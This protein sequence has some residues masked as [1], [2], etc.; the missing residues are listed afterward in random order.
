[1]LRF[2]DAAQLAQQVEKAIKSRRLVKSIQLKGRYSD[3]YPLG[4][5]IRK[6]EN[7]SLSRFQR[8]IS[9]LH[10]GY[11]LGAHQHAG[12]GLGEISIDEER[13]SSRAIRKKSIQESVLICHLKLRNSFNISSCKEGIDIIEENLQE[14]L[15]NVMLLTR[16]TG[17][18]KIQLH[19]N[20]VP[21][22][23]DNPLA[24]A[25]AT[26]HKGGW[27]WKWNSSNRND[28]ITVDIGRLKQSL[29]GAVPKF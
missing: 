9:L 1:M 26:K 10:W 18:S 27:C 20:D 7:W 29:G 16:V 19:E 5:K 11:V 15:N 24:S 13:R 3:K 4:V 21:L 2:N 22:M 25:L 14:W 6:P 8:A 23:M 17:Y 28:G 12:K